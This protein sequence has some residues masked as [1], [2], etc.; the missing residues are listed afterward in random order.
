MRVFSRRLLACG[1]AA[2][3]A[4]FA[5]PAARAEHTR[6]W[7]QATYED[8]D[9]GT[10]RGVALRSDGKLVLAPRF[11][12]FADPNAAY[13]W[14]LR[15]DSKGNLYAAGGS[16]AKVLRFDSKGTATTIFESAE[17]TAQALA[18]DAADNL[19]VGT[20]PDGKVYRITPAGEKKVF[21]EP[22]TKYIWALAVDA[23][24]TVYVAT[25]DKGEIFAVKPDGSGQVFYSSEET[26][27]RALALDGRGNLLAGTEPNGLILRISLADR[28]N[29]RQAFVLYESSKKEVTALLVDRAGN[30]FAAAIG[31]KPRPG[32]PIP[33]V[34]V[35]QQQAAGGQPIAAGGTMGP[36]PQGTVFVPFPPMVGSAV[37]RL[38]PD[39]APEELWS[40]RDDLVYAL[41]LSPGGKLLLGTGNRG[42]VIELE[43]HGVFSSLVKTASSQVTSLAQGPGGKVYLCTAN[44]GKIFTLGPDDEPVG[45]FE[46]QTFDARMFSQWGRL[47]WWGE[48]ADSAG[49][50]SLYVRSGNTSNA[51]KNWSPWAGPYS[52]G[53][54][55]KVN[56]PPARFVQWKAVLRSSSASPPKVS[57]VSLSYLPKNVA[58][59]V[60]A[61]VVQNPGVRVQGPSVPQ[62]G[63]TASQSVPLRM[64]PPAAPASGVSVPPQPERPP[65]RFEPP[66]QGFML[67][68]YQAV[69][70][71]ARDENDDELVYT[72][73]YRGEGEKNWR[74]LKE[75]LE[76]KF[77]SWDTSTMP[78]GAYY[79]KIVAS[80]APSNPPED[81]LMAERESDRFEVDNT[82]PVIENL[83][84]EPA[85]P[86]IRVRFD[87]RDSYS[88]IARAE[89]S[90]DGGD[91]MLVFPAGRLTDAPQE[92]FELVL[93]GL[94]PGEHTIAVRVF[95]RFENGAT[96]KVTFSV[97]AKKR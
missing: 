65:Q 61:I 70:W 74:L 96:S 26:H 57:W 58:P 72:I 60:D 29:A 64:P 73:Y 4:G 75:K 1:M 3:L 43:G 2:L 85:S 34:V 15:V 12:P 27:I 21:F 62:Q 82:P 35:T 49:K 25:G 37:Y 83:R 23:N 89:Y 54:G 59:T 31:E 19:Y 55:E 24:G 92:S 78:D 30:T 14:S 95:D 47:E 16:N 76:Q 71:S 77:Y 36:A 90:L 38:A 10:P 7:R 39:G 17:M 40:S 84:A 44:P 11:A 68:G 41:E 91:W 45:T 66:P 63:P 33:L 8:F 80:D 51:E 52:S 48:N 42:V 9:K 67:K 93:R 32:Q 53:R 69:V 56:C 28:S 88:D 81:A 6:Q 97:P 86:E 94:A 50:I 18:L 22:K 5:Q 87:A 13:L 79:L 20:S 46:S